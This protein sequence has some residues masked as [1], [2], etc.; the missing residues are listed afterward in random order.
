MKIP[1][2][3]KSKVNEVFVEDDSSS[4]FSVDFNLSAWL[5]EDF[6][7]TGEVE[8]KTQILKQPLNNQELMDFLGGEREIKTNY[9]FTPQQ[10]RY[11]VGQTDI[12]LTN[13]Y[14]NLFFVNNSDTNELYLVGIVYS[15][16]EGKWTPYIYRLHNLYRSWSKGNQVFTISNRF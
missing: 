7:G 12:L 11:L 1:N 4:F 3:P 14:S 10:I 16:K 5:P 15:Q 8:I 13:G 9:L 2:L 6:D